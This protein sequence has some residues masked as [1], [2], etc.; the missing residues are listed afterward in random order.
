M[1]STAIR[2]LAAV[3]LAL[4]VAVLAT[5]SKAAYADFFGDGPGL[6]SHTVT[7]IAPVIVPTTARADRPEQAHERR[8]KTS[9]AGTTVNFS[10]TEIGVYQPQ[11]FDLGC[12]TPSGSTFPVGI[13]LVTC[14][15]LGFDQTGNLVT[16]YTT[17]LVVVDQDDAPLSSLMSKLESVQNHLNHGSVG[18]ACNQL[19]AFLNEVKAQTGKSLT[20]AQAA[21]LTTGASNARLIIGCH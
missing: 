6:G 4:V 20:N 16:D 1:R 7:F 11:V 3:A 5:A 10:V 9:S 21:T 8:T 14:S 2:L 18:A 13:T 19:G 15:A 12:D 17:I